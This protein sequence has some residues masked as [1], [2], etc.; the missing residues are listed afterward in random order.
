MCVCVH[1]TPGVY[2]SFA[3]NMWLSGSDW[4]R[5]KFF[6]KH[7]LSLGGVP[8]VCLCVCLL[9]RRDV[10]TAMGAAP[11]EYGSVGDGSHECTRTRAIFHRPTHSL[12]KHTP[13]PHPHSPP[14]SKVTLY[15]SRPFLKSGGAPIPALINN[16]INYASWE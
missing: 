14:P 8:R 10:S 1:L 2:V 16:C 6:F 4:P 7:G 3:R 5:K 9:N 11:G 13:P 12:R 15:H